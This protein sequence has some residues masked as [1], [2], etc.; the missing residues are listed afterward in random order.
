MC[1]RAGTCEGILEEV[2]SAARRLDRH[3]LVGTGIDSSGDARHVRLTGSR[4][5]QLMYDATYKSSIYRDLPAALA[6]REDG[7][8]APLL[9]LAAED[10]AGS[11]SGNP[12]SYS[13]GAY[14]AIA[15]HD[16]PT[17]WDR[18][19]PVAERRE[20]LEA[21]IDALATD[22]FAPFSLESY[23]R[24]IWEVQIVRGCIRWPAPGS[25]DASMPTLEPHPDLPVL[26]LNG[27]FDITTPLSNGMDA[28]AA[29]PNATFVQVANEIHISALYDYERCAS[30]IV[31][32]FVL[33]HDAGDT[34]C[35]AETPEIAVVERFPRLVADAPNAEILGKMDDSAPGD[36]R[37][38]WAVVQTVADAFNRWWNETYG[39]GVGLR[40][41]TFSVDG[42]FYSFARPL[43]IS[44]DEARFVS[45]VAVSG[46]VVWHRRAAVAIGRLRVDAP[47]SS[48]R[49]AIRFDTD[50]HGDVT[51]IIGEL[52]GRRVELVTDR[53]WTS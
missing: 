35:A 8:E 53:A 36:R 6:A 38:A 37:V 47:G 49:V 7:D 15:C 18:S 43:V 31:R 42:P 27:E 30:R 39:G 26:V 1:E 2:G 19:A 29:W 10:L 46:T 5:A 45:D 52:G 13:E 51:T 25:G 21:A 14:A 40:G 20:Q 44:F 34:S 4:L 28:A 16:Y 17:I 32:R 50:R 9:R 22:A 33:T 3:P 12:R 41:G 11:G 48:G 23:L 24:M